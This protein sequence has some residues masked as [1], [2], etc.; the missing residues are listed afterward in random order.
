MPGIESF[1]GV[2]EKATAVP[3]PI[4]MR[5][6]LPGLLATLLFY[7]LAR[8]FPDLTGALTQHLGDVLLLVASIVVI[9]LLCAAFSN[10]FYKL[11][12]GR[13]GWPRP[14]LE[15]ALRRQ[16]NRTATMFARQ[17]ELDQ[18]EPEFKELWLQL[19]DYPT[20][21]N[22]EPR[23]ESPTHLGN[24]VFTYEGYPDKRYGMDAA[25]YWTRLWMV[26]DKD[27]KEQI[28]NEWSKADGFLAMS[29]VS[30][31]GGSV[32]LILGVLAWFDV[33]WTRTPTNSAM[34]FVGLLVIGLGYV[35]YLSTIPFCRE[36]GERFKAIFD[37]YRSRIRKMTELKPGE[38][39]LWDAA[40]AYYQYRM[41]I[42][43]ICG[44][45]N[46][47]SKNSCGNCGAELANS[48]VNFR[49]TGK[50]PL[51]PQ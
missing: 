6:G 46:D 15:W 49:Q 35:F 7:P 41:L 31:L 4:L 40:W 27:V 29:A 25:F 13:Y 24:I 28:D 36:N 14:V 30:F 39:A 21:E 3:F 50:F 1:S 5:V 33:S 16:Q 9:G 18:N 43:E 12:E 32:W 2:A 23:A 51:K 17:K 22:D 38:E 48:Q 11:Y 44:N 37:V 26:M 8:P 34:P 20:D 47:L 19:R 45:Y 42:C 10:E